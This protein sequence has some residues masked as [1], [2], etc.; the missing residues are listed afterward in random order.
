M[1][2]PIDIAWFAGIFEADG[3]GRVNIRPN[4]TCHGANITVT[5]ID[6]ECIDRIHA[7]LGIGN[8]Y[9]P[10][11]PT[12]AGNLTWRFQ[13]TDRQE[14]ARIC[15]G[16][17]PLIGPKKGSQIVKIADY[18]YDHIP[19]PRNCEHCDGEYTPN[20]FRG[21]ASRS[22]YC[23]PNCVKNAYRKRKKLSQLKAAQEHE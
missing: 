13:I 19:R 17:Y 9:G 7:R 5:M 14:L 2:N 15:L 8:V 11:G 10:Y 6:K 4:G 18:L 1:M 21:S 23:S 16:I 22:K 3:N 20:G 12:T